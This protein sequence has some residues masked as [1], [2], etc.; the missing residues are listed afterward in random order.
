MPGIETD[1]RMKQGET[2]MGNEQSTAVA[3]RGGKY[4]T[5]ALGNEH[6]GIEILKVREIIGRMTITRVPGLREHVKGV[7]NLRGQVVSVVDLRMRLGLEPVQ[8]TEHTCIV[9]V[10]TRS[11]GT[12]VNT[13]LIVDRVLEVLDV[14]EEA[15]V[16]NPELGH[17]VDGALLLGLGK[18]GDLVKILL[19]VDAVVNFEC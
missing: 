12:K 5:L 8:P 15:I 1:G 10:E 3:A 17:E 9:V 4:L 2:M 6:Y 19:D 16:A 11:G 18:V 7:I 13:G 14:P